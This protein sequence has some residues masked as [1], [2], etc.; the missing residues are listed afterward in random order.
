[1]LL[2]LPFGRFPWVV[3][4]FGAVAVSIIVVVIAI[5]LGN[6]AICTSLLLGFFLRRSTSVAVRSCRH[7]DLNDRS[8]VS[9]VQTV[10]SS[11][12]CALCL[13]VRE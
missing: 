6:L 8:V 7:V 2:H 3:H 12:A 9:F 11:S 13:C 5:V 4:P 1:M 10:V